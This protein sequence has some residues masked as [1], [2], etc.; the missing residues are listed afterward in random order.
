MVQAICSSKNG[1]PVTLAAFSLFWTFFMA[2][3]GKPF[4]FEV[5]RGLREPP[6]DVPEGASGALGASLSDSKAVFTF[7][8]KT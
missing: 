6:I 5:G 7:N 4:R 8:S 3:A 1:H 2:I